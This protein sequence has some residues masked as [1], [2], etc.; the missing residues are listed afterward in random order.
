M[1]SNSMADHYDA[2]LGSEDTERRHRKYA[3]IARLGFEP[4]AA[5]R[6]HIEKLAR[7]RRHRF[8]FGRAA[9]RASKRGLQDH[10]SLLSGDQ[11]FGV[12]G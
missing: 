11:L 1:R 8:F 2:P 3:A 12:D 10:F 7:I 6:T 4:R 5:T 9:V